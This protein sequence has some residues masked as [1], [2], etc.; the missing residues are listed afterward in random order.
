[1]LLYLAVFTVAAA[2]DV[3]WTRYI[4]AVGARKA[5]P[6]GMWAM[7]TLLLGAFGIVSY[8]ADHWALIPAALGCF[9]GTYLTVLRMGR[10]S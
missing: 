7:G 5:A 6:A 9:A 8:T 1:M 10:A 2:N 3:V 4:A